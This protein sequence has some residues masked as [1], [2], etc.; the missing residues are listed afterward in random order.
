MSKRC[1]QWAKAVF[2]AASARAGSSALS[3]YQAA[4]AAIQASAGRLAW[5]RAKMARVFSGEMAATRACHWSCSSLRR[6]RV[7]ALSSWR[8]WGG[9]RYWPISESSSAARPQGCRAVRWPWPR[10]GDGAGG[11]GFEGAEEFHAVEQGGRQEVGGLEGEMDM[12]EEEF[13]AGNALGGADGEERFGIEERNGVIRG[14]S[15]MMA[16]MRESVRRRRA[17]AS[18]A[19][20]KSAAASA[21]RFS[22]QGHACGAEQGFG[23]GGVEV[24][25]ALEKSR[26]ASNRLVAASAAMAARSFSRTSWAAASSSGSWWRTGRNRGG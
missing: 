15:R 20:E 17:S 19:R 24:D 11:F 5:R 22:L 4:R 16:L 25:D 26:A 21:V 1:G 7:S 14:A 12:V 2:A 8:R 13:A 9:R 23:M 3:R 6:T 18:R 10:G